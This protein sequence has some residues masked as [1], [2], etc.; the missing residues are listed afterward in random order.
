MVPSAH[1]CT[2]TQLHLNTDFKVLVFYFFNFPN[3]ATCSYTHTQVF[4]SAEV[5]V[6]TIVLSSFWYCKH[7][8]YSLYTVQGV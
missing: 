1:V 3:L 2:D 6:Y 8:T 7:C 5:Q 4:S